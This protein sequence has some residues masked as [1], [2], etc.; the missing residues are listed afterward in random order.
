MAD[1]TFITGGTR[2][3]K[4]SFANKLAEE[5][6]THPV[7]LATARIWDDDFKERVKRHQNDRGDHWQTIE[8]EKSIDKIIVGGKTVVLDCITLWLT[9]IFHDNQYNL[10]KSLAEAKKIWDNFIQQDFELIAVSN[11]LGLSIHP[12]N[13]IARKFTDLQGFMNQHI[14][15]CSA[16]T[17]LVVSGIPIKIK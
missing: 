7:C 16:H 9:N 13:K 3:G 11:E 15:S 17:Y 8:E 10:D 1:I 4:S 2:S 6:S 12:D 14:A 5:N